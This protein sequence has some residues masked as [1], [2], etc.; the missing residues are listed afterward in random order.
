MISFLF[1]MFPFTAGK[2]LFSH[3]NSLTDWEEFIGPFL[4]I[5]LHF[6]N[7]IIR[8]LSCLLQR[9]CSSLKCIWPVEDG[10]VGMQ[11]YDKWIYL[12]LHNLLRIAFIL[13]TCIFSRDR[14]NNTITNKPRHTPCLTELFLETRSFIF[15]FQN[16]ENKCKLGKRWIIFWF[17]FE[18]HVL[19]NIQIRLITNK[20]VFL[21]EFIV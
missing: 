21:H 1:D 15:Q 14:Y 3:G 8:V 16:N 10:P 17:S 9:T 2:E 7:I 5:L 6:F 4:N 11:L 19:N 13:N 12:V 18:S 20:F